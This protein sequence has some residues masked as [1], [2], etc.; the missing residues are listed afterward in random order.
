M[1]ADILIINNH[2]YSRYIERKGMNW[3][4]ND[5]DS[6][7]TTRTKD[8]TLRRDK[9]TTK[10]TL[11]YKMMNMDREALAQLDNDLSEDTFTV[12][13]LDLHGQQT[14]TFY[15]SS[16]SATLEEVSNGVDGSWGSATFNIIE[17]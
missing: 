10:R 9:I 17:V 3:K 4:R 5:L 11:G 14:R 13:Y 12:Q 15:C 1:A 7:K 8:G 16:F 2:N 6:G